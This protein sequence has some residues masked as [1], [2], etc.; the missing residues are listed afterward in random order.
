MRNSTQSKLDK[1]DVYCAAFPSGE[2]PEITNHIKQ[3]SNKALTKDKKA[4]IYIRN[5]ACKT[6]YVV[7]CMAIS[8]DNSEPPISIIKN[9][10]NSIAT[11]CKKEMHVRLLSPAQEGRRGRQG[12]VCR[13]H[14]HLR[15]E[16]GAGLFPD[17]F[18]F[19]LGV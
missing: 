3:Q 19:I 11:T 12:V 1:I 15:L 16:E 8:K 7:Y 6:N 17:K 18:T 9:M 10:N 14:L 5:L 2:V 4:T 13:S